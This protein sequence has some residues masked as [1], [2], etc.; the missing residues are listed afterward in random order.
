MDVPPIFLIDASL[1]LAASILLVVVAY[2]AFHGYRVLGSN[3]LKIITLAFT[4]I[5]IGHAVHALI[6]IEVAI[7]VA[8]NIIRFPSPKFFP[9]IRFGYTLCFLLEFL[10]YLILAYQYLKG[11]R[12]HLLQLIF[13]PLLLE[14]QPQAE[15]ILFIFS[16]LIFLKILINYLRRR[17]RENL[18]VALGFMF[19]MLY[20]LIL[21]ATTF[22]AILPLLPII[23]PILLAGSVSFLLMLL[24][25]IRRT[26]EVETYGK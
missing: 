21:L 2:Y 19:F 24:R 8:T 3:S 4:F 23:Y 16:L 12:E 20:H 13:L 11:N 7:L 15:V 10:A 25:I 18:Y 14:Y 9:P 1:E 5:G 22:F 6:K 17:T 26:P